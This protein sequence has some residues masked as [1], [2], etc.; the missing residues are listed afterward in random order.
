MP[1]LKKPAPS[2]RALQTRDRSICSY[3]L[4]VREWCQKKILYHIKSILKGIL[5]VYSSFLHLS[6]YKF[7]RRV[8]EKIKIQVMQFFGTNPKGHASLLIISEIEADKGRSYRVTTKLQSRLQTDESVY[9]AQ[10]LGSN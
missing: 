9:N 1:L 4:N 5:K 7:F 3:G 2:D 6:F 10:S 8:F